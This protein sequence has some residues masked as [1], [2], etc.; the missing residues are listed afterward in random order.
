MVGTGAKRIGIV[1]PNGVMDGPVRFAQGN[2]RKLLPPD[3]IES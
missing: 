1:H 2:H 3:R